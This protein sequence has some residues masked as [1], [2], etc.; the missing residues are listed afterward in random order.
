MPS[1]N[2]YLFE[3]LMIFIGNKRCENSAGSTIEMTD[4]FELICTCCDRKLIDTEILP[5][6]SR[7]KNTEHFQVLYNRPKNVDTQVLMQFVH[8]L[9]G[10]KFVARG[11]SNEKF[12]K[13]RAKLLHNLERS[14]NHLEFN[15]LLHQ[16]TLVT[17]EVLDQNLG[18]GG[19]SHSSSSTNIV[20]SV[21][22]ND[23]NSNLTYIYKETLNLF[24]DESI[25]SMVRGVFIIQKFIRLIKTISNNNY[26][27]RSN[28]RLL[29]FIIK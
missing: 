6:I 25:D 26:L 11:N 15:R 12:G 24:A 22:Q 9:S 3:A 10:N 13:I 28:R 18:A 29:F 21:K 5:V 27:T 17:P 7:R 1:T 14:F 16:Q 2:Q 19:E 20:G 4:H 23:T 8:V